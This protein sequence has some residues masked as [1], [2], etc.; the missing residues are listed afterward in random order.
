MNAQE[1]EQVSNVVAL[2][3]PN[4]NARKWRHL[5]SEVLQRIAA[6][7]EA[8]P[9]EASHAETYVRHLRKH[10]ASAEDGRAW[11]YEGGKWCVD[12]DIIAETKASQLIRAAGGRPEPKLVKD[13]LF[14]LGRLEHP[15][16]CPRHGINVKNGFLELVDGEWRLAPHDSAHG[17]RY[18]LPFEYQ[19]GGSCPRWEEFLKQTQPDPDV[20]E[21]LRQFFGWVLLGSRRPHEER[22]A[23][24]HG[25]G[26]NGKSVALGVL[27]SLVG[28][29][30]AASLS[31]HEFVGRNVELLSGKLV[32][33]GSE[34]ERAERVETAML[35]KLVS[36]EPV[37]A[38]PKY[39]HHYEVT[40]NAVLVFAVNDVPPIDDRSGGIWRRLLLVSWPRVIDEAAREKDLLRYLVEHELPGILSWAL[41]G[42]SSV[43]TSGLFVPASVAATSAR[44]RLDNNCVAMFAQDCTEAEGDAVI[45]KSDLYRAFQ[46]WCGE[47]GYK[48]VSEVNFG[49]DLRRAVPGLKDAKTR[50]GYTD[51][52]GRRIS[53]RLNAYAGLHVP[54]ERITRDV[55]VGGKRSRTNRPIG[56]RANA[57]TTL[58]H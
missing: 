1:A 38:T 58:Q 48:A 25:D 3:Q 34:T 23:V 18:V 32:N 14:G 55:F 41:V 42:A 54:A 19:P 7:T 46:C 20:I 37:L 50:T 8:K 13:I 39:R 56:Q 40:C 44:L 49:K 47:R 31:L 27:K 28:P 9:K 11:Y 30:N 33:L 6:V 15:V 16:P 12:S 29:A 22:F 2:D 10:F 53:S 43:L 17:Q 21:H 4:S 45:S 52:E 51:I 57:A 35:K 36:C 5:P 24:W 26:A